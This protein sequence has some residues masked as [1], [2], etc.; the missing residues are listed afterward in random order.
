MSPSE[1]NEAAVRSPIRYNCCVDAAMSVIEGRWKSTIIC[2]LFNQGGMRF[3]ELER[4]IG[5]VSSRILSKQLKE[6]EEDGMI[7]RTVAP[8][9]KL[10]VVY[11]L[12][13]KGESILPILGS[14]A[15]WGACHQMIEVI[16]PESIGN[17]V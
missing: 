6:L 17:E 14:L 13:A 10:K 16:T 11:S 1:R 7:I 5:E 2:M 9:K 3:S 4:R 15:E 12:S 8:D